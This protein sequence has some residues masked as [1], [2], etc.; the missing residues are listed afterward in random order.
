MLTLPTSA[1][2][3]FFASYDFDDAQ[4]TM[5]KAISAALQNRIWQEER[6]SLLQRWLF[7]EAGMKFTKYKKGGAVVKTIIP[8]PAT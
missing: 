1:A 2:F 4:S 5:Q 8:S 6:G 3:V 7:F